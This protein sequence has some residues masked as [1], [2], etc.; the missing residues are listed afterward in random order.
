MNA[1]VSLVIVTGPLGPNEA[2][3]RRIGFPN[4]EAPAL[5][6]TIDW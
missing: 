2:D 4:E 5:R 1:G 6:T 3:G